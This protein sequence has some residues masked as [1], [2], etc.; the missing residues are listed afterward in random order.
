LLIMKILALLTVSMLAGVLAFAQDQKVINDPNAQK[1]P[2]GDFHAIRIGG[3]IELY[4]SQGGEE[5]VAVSA[6][7]PEVRD[8]IVTE[9]TDGVLHIHLDDNWHWNWNRENLKLRAYV[10]CKVLDELKASGGTVVNIDQTIKSERLNVHL[11]GG[12]RIRGNFEAGEMTVGISGGGDLYIGG[13]A[14]H[15]DVHVSGGGDFHGYDLAVD[16]C[17]ARVSGGGDVFVTVN[18]TLDAAVHGGGD[19]RYKGNGSV[20][21]SHT[22]GGGSISKG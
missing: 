9:V 18:K 8:R 20:Q 5:A 17:Q 22:A 6:S 21:E 4:L 13:T 1:R 10:S 14:G 15:L 19:I 11:S 2:V 7:D 12:G 3:G 16:S